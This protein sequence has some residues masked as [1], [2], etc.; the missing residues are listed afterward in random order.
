[1][2]AEAGARRPQPD[3]DS[4][5]GGGAERARRLVADAAGGV[6]RV[7]ITPP[8]PPA[9]VHGA[10]TTPD[11]PPAGATAGRTATACSATQPTPI[12]ATRLA[13]ALQRDERATLT[14]PPR[15]GPR[16]TRRP[17]ALAGGGPPTREKDS[18]APL[19]GVDRPR[20]ADSTGGGQA[21]APPTLTGHAA[22][23]T[24]AHREATAEAAESAL[25]AEAPPDPTAEPDQAPATKPV[26][27]EGTPSPPPEKRAEPQPAPAQCA[28]APPP[29]APSPDHS[30]SEDE[31]PKAPTD[32][33]SDTPPSTPG[34]AV[35]SASPPPLQRTT[36]PGHR[37]PRDASRWLSPVPVLHATDRVV[38]AP[39]PI[40]GC[41]SQCNT[42]AGLIKH[43]RLKHKAAGRTV[44]QALALQRALGP[45]GISFCAIHESYSGLV[46]GS[47]PNRDGLHTIR[48]KPCTACG[49]S[50]RPPL[51]PLHPSSF[52]P[53]TPSL[54]GKLRSPPATAPAATATA[55]VTAT[56]ARGDATPKPVAPAAPTVA[57]APPDAAPPEAGV[58]AA[59]THTALATPPPT[60]SA[61][62]LADP[63][64]TANVPTLSPPEAT[65]PAASATTAHTAPAPTPP[66]LAAP[67]SGPLRAADPATPPPAPHEDE[68]PPASP[69]ATTPNAH[70]IP[71]RVSADTTADAARTT[72]APEK[73]DSDPAWAA[74]SETS[75][76]SSSSAGT[77]VVQPAPVALL[78][79]LRSWEGRDYVT[80]MR[81]AGQGR[82]PFGVTKAHRVLINP[83]DFGSLAPDG[84]LT[85]AIIT[86]H[87]RTL[88][89]THP[90]TRTI[91]PLLYTRLTDK[92][93]YDFSRVQRWYPRERRLAEQHDRLLLPVCQARHWTLVVIELRQRF[94]LY[95]DPLGACSPDDDIPTTARRWLADDISARY[96]GAPV[97]E[98]L[99]GVASWPI[100][101]ADDSWP[102]QQD[103]M[104][105][106]MFVMGVMSL[107]AQGTRARFTQRDIPHMRK[108]ALAT[109]LAAPDAL[110]V[111]PAGTPPA[112][113]DPAPRHS[114]SPP[115]SPAVAASAAKSPDDRRTT[116]RDATVGPSPPLPQGE[117]AALDT[118][119]DEPA[120]LGTPGTPKTPPSSSAR[121]QGLRQRR[122]T[123][124]YGRQDTAATPSSTDSAS[125]G[126]RQRRSRQRKSSGRRGGTTRPV[127]AAASAPSPATPVAPR[128]A[129][130]APSPAAPAT[131]ESGKRRRHRRTATE[132]AAGVKPRWR[133]KSKPAPASQAVPEAPP[134]Q[135]RRPSKHT[136]RTGDFGKVTAPPLEELLTTRIP[137]LGHIPAFSRTR[138]RDTLANVLRDVD[139]AKAPREASNALA[140]AMAFAKCILFLPPRDSTE[141]SLNQLVRTRLQ[142][143][144]HGELLGLWAEARQAAETRAAPAGS[145][146]PAARPH[147]RAIRLAQEG[148]HKKALTALMSEGV[149]SLS[150]EIQTALTA[151]HPQ[152]RA[153]SD[154]SFDNPPFGAFPE[155]TPHTPFTAAEVREALE[156]SPP[157]SAAGGSGLSFQHLKEMVRTDGTDPLK[158][159]AKSLATFADRIATGRIEPAL[160]VWFASAPL[161]PLRKRDGGVRPIAIGESLR[162]LVGKMLMRRVRAR[163]SALLLPSQLGVGVRC[164]SEA[165]V[166]A[167]R[168]AVQEGGHD[169]RIALL[170]LDFR[171]AFNLVSRHAMERAVRFHFPELSA[172]FRLCY[173][174]EEDPHLW[175]GSLRLRSA[176]GCQQGDPLG[177]L[178]F[179][180]ALHDLMASMPPPP[181]PDDLDADDAPPQ[182][183][184]PPL[185]HKVMMYIDDGLVVGPHS[186][187]RHIL[188][189]LRSP[190][191]VSYGL[192]LRPDKCTVWWPSAP[193]ANTCA[194]YPPEVRQEFSPGISVMQA[195]IGA[196]AFVRNELLTRV[197]ALRPMFAALSD[198]TDAHVV[199]TLLRSCLS[200]C[201]VIYLLRVTPT[202]L[203][204]PAAEH[205]DAMLADTLRDLV[206]GVLPDNLLTE[207]RLPVR[208]SVPTFGIG[209][210]SAT[211]TAS[212]AHL[213]SLAGSRWLL[214]SLLPNPSQRYIVDSPGALLAHADWASRVLADDL[215]PLE[216][217]LGTDAPPQRELARRVT[218]RTITELA[219]GDPRRQAHRASLSIHGSKDWLVCRPSPGLF[220]H[221]ADPDFRLWLRFHC[222]VRL[223]ND[224][225]KC[226]REN[227]KADV[228]EF[229]DHLLVCHRRVSPG[230]APLHWRHDSLVQIIAATLRRAARNATVEPRGEYAAGRERPDI[231]ADGVHGG[232]DLLDVTVAHP[233]TSSARMTQVTRWPQSILTT[234]MTRKFDKYHDLLAAAGPQTRLLPLAVTTL[235]GWHADALK[236]LDGVCDA[237][238]SRTRA[239]RSYARGIVLHRAAAALVRLNCRSL[240]EGLNTS[241]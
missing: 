49:P 60:T 85:D 86:I 74:P 142:R 174:N 220:C 42:A 237:I 38:H 218:K 100:W 46:N 88:A 209:L 227:C 122:Q 77:E 188:S 95:Y 182:A 114:P 119:G 39:C 34:Q 238:A 14:C 128:A 210:T 196:D 190:L 2:G 45:Y 185:G 134:P 192:H 175:C 171:N 87:G 33:R 21:S 131:Q 43:M 224:G 116:A 180:L 169:P 126:R 158:S 106:G 211:S 80:A 31:V 212:A 168:S 102:R 173:L 163:A 144:H 239:P 230:N 72:A 112:R 140:C 52:G 236:Y 201:R 12:G 66:G 148:A 206:G 166:H 94:V 203:A 7:L 24:N 195:P 99:Q 118:A 70:I 225:M 233:L 226:P 104:S 234:A 186:T 8:P 129:A 81:A 13:C 198:I 68:A 44:K 149:H 155:L 130:A 23:D 151:K 5:S 136:L 56:A 3:S 110:R 50:K 167:V 172:Y 54:A 15:S 29:T 57:T 150:P 138:A 82:A 205:F 143:W 156:A 79:P 92:P 214:D 19:G 152:T 101:T 231:R 26:E 96:G 191:T 103:S 189:F 162:R 37:H 160:A 229:G 59:R 30:S 67:A 78:R 165:I 61:H 48:Y 32:T 133:Q 69:S 76:S 176:T 64:T 107:F 216:T 135:V 187:L 241:V 232:T 127:P 83:E 71:A 200:T 215:L 147:A 222:G 132:I 181:R 194:A 27:P 183:D 235:G 28:R 41:F 111:H 217:I 113:R 125:T 25:Q 228:D 22:G 117:A 179:S 164:G 65:E 123:P 17:E 115:L 47:R 178:F 145:G 16:T 84:L 4:R 221:I 161:S 11:L 51:W 208:T 6:E 91:D 213:A 108:V 53:E 184:E 98:R 55:T 202:P 170:Q 90:S 204:L 207:L 159:L 58:T 197:A 240:T 63:A 75:D 199:L 141:M 193:G 219:P 62:A 223:F 154:P 97:P 124:G 9:G 36:T 139:R 89:Q 20:P 109:V 93:G 105:C 73:D 157:A 177:P 1:M 10:L 137:V 121:R 153:E 120:P 40:T 35:F 146:T 18:T